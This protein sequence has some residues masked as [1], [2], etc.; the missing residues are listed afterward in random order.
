[1]TYSSLNV[2]P[3]MLRMLQAIGSWNIYNYTQKDKDI[4]C[5]SLHQF[6]STF[7]TDVRP[8]TVNRKTT[9]TDLSKVYEKMSN[10]S[11]FKIRD[12]CIIKA[13]RRQEQHNWALGYAG[14]HSNTLCQ[15]ISGHITHERHEI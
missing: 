11:S 5:L 15:I 4:F 9:L 3:E 13:H 1:M 6:F 7:T 14:L 10:K 12:R 2:E 8:N